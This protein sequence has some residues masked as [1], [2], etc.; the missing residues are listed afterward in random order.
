MKLVMIKSKDKAHTACF[1]F[2]PCSNSAAK[3]SRD[4]MTS[5]LEPESFWVIG[6][7]DLA[8][9]ICRGEFNDIASEVRGKTSGSRR[10]EEYLKGASEQ[11]A[12]PH[13]GP[14]P[15][16]VESFRRWSWNKDW[17]QRICRVGLC[18]T[19]LR[20]TIKECNY[21]SI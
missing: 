19:L 5:F 1:N 8:H 2:V 3:S 18:C 16:Y 21:I 4:V 14:A 10:P 12:Y 7:I 17:Q 13:C 11:H 9:Q 6:F 20:H 15:V